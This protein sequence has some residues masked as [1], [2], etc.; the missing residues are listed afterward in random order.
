MVTKS[1]ILITAAKNE[2]FYI[3][4]TIKSVISQTVLP[5]RW[6]IVSDGSTDNTETIVEHYTKKH[7]FIDLLRLEQKS[8]RDFASKVKAIH[9]A[10]KHLQDTQY[11]FFGSLDADITFADTYYEN[12]LKAFAKN[13]NLGIAGGTIYDVLDGNMLMASA[14]TNNIGSATQFFRRQCYENIGGYLP[15]QYGGEDTAAEVMARMNGWEVK[16]IPELKVFHHR[17]TGTGTWGIRAAKFYSGKEAYFLGYHPLF[18]LFKS[19]ARVVQKPHLTGP[20]L[21]LA[22]YCFSFFDKQTRQVSIDFVKYIRREQ[23]KRLKSSL[24]FLHRD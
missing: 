3:E 20:I 15:L 5:K 24:I 12:L 6:T 13:P 1:Y 23:L 21:M 11:S 2:E 8:D 19:V 9:V 17:R 4:N 22:G 14:R 7:N 10:Y 16:L 18:F